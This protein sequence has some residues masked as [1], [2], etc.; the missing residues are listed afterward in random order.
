MTS[1][2][3]L[4]QKFEHFCDHDGETIA[5]EFLKNG[6]TSQKTGNLKLLEGIRSHIVH[7]LRL[8]LANR[9]LNVPSEISDESLLNSLHCYVDDRFEINDLRMFLYNEI[10]RSSSV[11]ISIANCVKNALFKIV[12]SE[13]SIQTSVNLSIMMPN[14]STSNIQLHVDNH[15]GES[16]YEIVIWMP[17]TAVYESKSLCIIPV[18]GFRDAVSEFETSFRKGGVDYFIDKYQEKLVWPALE[19][20]EY[21][22]FTP[23]LFHGSVV[24]RTNETRW[25]VNLRFK[26]LLSPDGLEPKATGSFFEPLSVAPATIL[27][28]DLPDLPGLTR[29]VHE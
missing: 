22:L 1:R 3:I 25:S 15:S 21:L 14:D 23:S 29:F 19:Y 20:G 11:R 27:A 4:N 16:L 24:N 17:L 12:G 26:S 2:E 8:Y 28:L 5:S 7:L 13:L 18:E 9:K 6:F 10:N